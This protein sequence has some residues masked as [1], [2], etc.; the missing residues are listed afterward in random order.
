M[1][2][3]NIILIGFM[4]TGKTTI[5]KIVSERLNYK[6]VDTDDLIQ[7]VCN[8]TIPDIFSQKGEQYFRDVEKAVI[9]QISN[10]YNTVIACGGGV[11][12]N[13]KNIDNLK[14]NGVLICL[15]CDI[16]ILYNRITSNI[17]RPLASGKS[18]EDILKLMQEREKMYKVADEFIDTSNASEF[19][20]S[21]R[22]INIYEIYN[23]K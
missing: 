20:I 10:N 17:D 9:K 15:T 21:D 14:S 6:F 19:D 3:L 8:M 18:K 1:D 23:S 5:G 7:E 22:I 4:G 16:E 12:K 13:A 11:V 2:N